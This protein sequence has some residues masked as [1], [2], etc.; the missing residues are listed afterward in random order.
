MA[1]RA[2][3]VQQ[4]LGLGAGTPRTPDPGTEQ[5]TNASL[6]DCRLPA[7]DPVRSPAASAP[8][9]R[10]WGSWR[11]HQEEAPA[12]PAGWR[13]GTPGHRPPFRLLQGTPPLP[14]TPALP[15][16]LSS[17]GPFS[18]TRLIFEKSCLSAP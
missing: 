10:R 14:G 18:Q 1:E 16:P 17:L 7:S 4:P 11:K 15:L 5:K 9:P 2:V 3:G 6:P 12:K 8:W 13:G